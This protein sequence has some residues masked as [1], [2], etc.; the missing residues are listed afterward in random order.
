MKLAG[1]YHSPLFERIKEYLGNCDQGETVFL[2][3][4]FIKKDVLRL[5]IDGIKNRIVIVT[6]WKPADILSGSSELELFPLCKERKIALYISANLHLKVYSV[7]LTNA[8]LAT[9]NISR[10]GLLPSGNYEAATILKHLTNED[11]LFFEKIRREARLV[12]DKMYEEYVKWR[13]E[14]NVDIPKQVRLQDVVSDPKNNNFSVASLPMTHSI[15]DLVLGYERIGRGL[16]PSDYVEVSA[17]VF[18]DLA[19]YEISPGLSKDEFMKELTRQFFKHPFVKKIDEFIAPESYFGRIKEWIQDNCTDVPVS[20]QKRDYR[21]RTG[22][23]RMVY[24]VGRRKIYCR[25]AWQKI[26]TNQ[27]N[28]CIEIL[29]YSFKNSLKSVFGILF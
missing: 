14:N 29:V 6:T 1:L 7:D 22:V 3:V 8:I 27:K 18:H 13:D 16:E 5:L 28:H 12:D 4:P 20:K 21:E 23:V 26:P 19:N 25:C 15:D 2:F 9:G 10:R 24:E 11:R 17:C